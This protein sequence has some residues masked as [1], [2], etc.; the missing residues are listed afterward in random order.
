MK[1]LLAAGGKCQLLEQSPGEE[2]ACV[3]DPG[4][5]HGSVL[6]CCKNPYSKNFQSFCLSCVALRKRMKTFSL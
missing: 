4:N 2:K 6:K 1:T 3:A 5:M